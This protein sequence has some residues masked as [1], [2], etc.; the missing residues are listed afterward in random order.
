MKK[1]LLWELSGAALIIPGPSGIHYT[2]QANGCTCSQPIIEGYLIPINNDRLLT[3]PEHLETQLCMLFDGFDTGLPEA[4]ATEIDNLLARFPET[5]GISVDREKISES[6][7][8]W[9]HVIAKE[10]EFSCY[11]GFGEIKGILTWNNSD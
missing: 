3:D 4:K 7:E 2:N 8:A 9:V 11:S 10:T 6:M 5:E 1:V